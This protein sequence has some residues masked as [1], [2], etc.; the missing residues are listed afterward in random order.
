MASQLSLPKDL[1]GGCLSS[2]SHHGMEEAAADWKSGN[3]GLNPRLAVNLWCDLPESL[4]SLGLFLTG[5]LD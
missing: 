3:P 5:E 4:V 1:H 2:P